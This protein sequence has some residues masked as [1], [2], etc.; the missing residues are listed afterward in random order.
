MLPGFSLKRE[1]V[2]GESTASGPR[3]ELVLQDKSRAG[4]LRGLAV[5]SN[6]EPL[7]LAL[8]PGVLPVVECDPGVV[9]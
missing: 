3:V 6:D 5:S 7:W 2:L 8:E 4:V 1:A 9:K